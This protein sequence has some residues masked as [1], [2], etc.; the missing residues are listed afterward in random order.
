MT[1]G[2]T[3][4]GYMKRPKVQA[5]LAG[6]DTELSLACDDY[7]T[8]FKEHKASTDALDC[9]KKR[10]AELMNKHGKNQISHDGY[11]IN[12]KEEKT[13]PESV[14]IKVDNYDR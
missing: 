1:Q 11:L 7:V 3:R 10:C 8:A 2:Y 5:T 13:I 12:F 14:S 6:T 4:V 9:A